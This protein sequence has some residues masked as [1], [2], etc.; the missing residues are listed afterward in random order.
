MS[1]LRSWRWA[2]PLRPYAIARPFEVTLLMS[3]LCSRKFF[4]NGPSGTKLKQEQS[5][6]AINQKASGTAKPTPSGS[7]GVHGDDV[8]MKD[9]SEANEENGTFSGNDIEQ[10]VKR[11]TAKKLKRD[12][13]VEREEAED[14]DDEP[15]LK[16]RKKTFT[17]KEEEK[18]AAAKPRKESNKARQSSVKAVASEAELPSKHPSKAATT[19]RE[20]PSAG[21]ASEE[22]GQNDSASEEEEEPQVAAK[23][24]EKLQSTLKSSKDPYTDWRQGTRSPTLPYVPLSPLSR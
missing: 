15:V 21:S 11:A 6:L 10:E 19:D 18:R 4:G 5:T 17:D 22:E 24:R 16:K 7:N 3:R 23:E 13:S 1:I 14:S 8:D 9:H 20:T 12:K 2:I